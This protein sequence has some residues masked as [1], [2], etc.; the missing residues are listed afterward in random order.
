MANV[1]V[2][3]GAT[4]G[5]T[6]ADWA[7]AYITL[8]AALNA[9]AAGD[10]FFVAHDHIQSSSSAL[11]LTSPGTEVLPC[12]IFCVNRAGSVPPVSADLRTTAQ[13]STTGASAINIAG[14]IMEC[15]GIIFSAGDTSNTA[16]ININ[17]TISRTVRMVSCA[18]K[19]GSTNTACRIVC[20]A[21]AGANITI[22]RN[23]TVQF[24]AVGQMLQT[25][26]KTI[27]RYTPNAIQG[28]IIPSSLLTFNGGGSWFLEGVDLSAL[29]SG[30]TIFTPGGNTPGNVLIVK[31]CKLGAGSG[32]TA[33]LT[34]GY[35]QI[36]P[37]L[38]CCDSGDTNYRTEKYSY[39]GTQ[40]V[41]TTIVRTGGASDGTTPIS[42]KFVTSA[43]SRFEMPFESLPISVWN[44]AVGVAKTITIQGIWGTAALPKN[45]D[46]YIVVE[47]L[48]TAGFPLG[49]IVNS[50]KGDGLAANAD[51]PAGSGTWGGGTTKF[52]MSVTITPQK[53]GQITIY[54]R[55]AKPSSTF[56]I[57]PK[58]DIA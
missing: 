20:C 2:W 10:V 33:A 34:V 50:S 57:D 38:I 23:T 46:V 44:E 49:N 36:E 24:G 13:I 8:Q 15:Y 53:K 21:G 54:V 12:R 35:G 32:V 22:L 18:L 42:W 41:E 39:A 43:N 26:G 45:D 6:G 11:T 51:V 3:N 28:A 48:G 17:T 1:Y 47:Y 37:V 30:K 14:T 31:D 9:K 56:Y 4:G 25:V 40:T 58:A 29:T 19:F 27:W 7:N 16:N 52:A 5:G 55:A